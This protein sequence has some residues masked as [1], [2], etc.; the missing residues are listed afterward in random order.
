MP[1]FKTIP[2]GPHSHGHFHRIQ[3]NPP[4]PQQRLQFNATLNIKEALLCPAPMNREHHFATGNSATSPPST[5][6]TRADKNVQV[7]AGAEGACNLSLTSISAT[8]THPDTDTHHKIPHL[9]SI[10]STAPGERPRRVRPIK[11]HNRARGTRIPRPRAQHAVAAVRRHRARAP[12]NRRL[13]SY[14]HPTAI[15]LSSY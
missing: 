12:P 14:S 5:T 8:P 10:C 2:P 11:S 9:Y 4:R 15:L 6:H 13:P 7:H 3:F 1:H